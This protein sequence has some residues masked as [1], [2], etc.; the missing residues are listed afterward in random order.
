[1]YGVSI[2]KRN[3]MRANKI[4]ILHIAHAA[5]GVDVIYEYF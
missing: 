2:Q 4:R 5:G 1:M 3:I